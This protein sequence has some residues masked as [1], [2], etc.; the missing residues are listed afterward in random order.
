L[1]EAYAEQAAALLEGGVDLLLVETV[2][3][4][5][6]AKAA[7]H[8][9]ADVQAGRVASGAAEGPVPVMLSGTITDASGRARSGPPREAFAV[10]AAHA[11]LLSGGLNWAL[12]AE[13]MRP[14][15]R[16]VAHATGAL[17]SVRPS[18]GLPNAFGGYEDTPGE[19]AEVRGSMAG[20]G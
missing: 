2:F 9:I 7:L 16:D 19:M 18:A 3:D 8:A 13:A 6:N 11:D 4:T 20:E 14:H 10:S 5:L 17:T 15:L 1:R 12:G